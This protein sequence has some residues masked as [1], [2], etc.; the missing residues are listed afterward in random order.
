MKASTIA[1]R[2]GS[3]RRTGSLA[4]SLTYR[5]STGSRSSLLMQQR[6][7]FLLCRGAGRVDVCKPGLKPIG[8]TQTHSG[9]RRFSICQLCFFMVPKTGWCRFKQ[10]P[11]TKELP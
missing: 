8:K 11:V 3:Y 4:L 10:R 1:D 9:T 7:D 2:S 6:W 5:R